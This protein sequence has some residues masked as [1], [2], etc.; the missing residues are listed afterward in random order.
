MNMDACDCVSQPTEQ[1]N[2]Y[3]H[4]LAIA[5]YIH[6]FVRLFLPWVPDIEFQICSI[7]EGRIDR[8]SYYVCMRGSK[9]HV[10]E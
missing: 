6:S 8:A 7:N 5:V 3:R 1:I 4:L 2:K 9:P 10:N